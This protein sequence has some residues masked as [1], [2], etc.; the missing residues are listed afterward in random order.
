MSFESSGAALFATPDRIQ[1]PRT[2]KELI[3]FL[4]RKMSVLN[5]DTKQ[6]E[7]MPGIDPGER[8]VTGFIAELNG[9]DMPELAKAFE[10]VHTGEKRLKKEKRSPT[11]Q[12]ELQFT[13]YR[14]ILQDLASTA[15]INTE[16]LDANITKLPDEYGQ[17]EEK[18]GEIILSYYELLLKGVNN[19]NQPWKGV[20]LQRVNTLKKQGSFR[21][22]K[23]MEK[24]AEVKSDTVT[25]KDI[26][27]DN[28]SQKSKDMASYYLSYLSQQ[29][30]IRDSKA[31][32]AAE[33]IKNGAYDRTALPT[34]LDVRRNFADKLLVDL[35]ARLPVLTSFD[36]KED[37]QKAHV[38]LQDAANIYLF[39]ALDE[40]TP[41]P[42]ATD[43]KNTLYQQVKDLTTDGMGLKSLNERPAF[44]RQL[45]AKQL[46]ILVFYK[47]P[48]LNN[49]PASELRNIFADRLVLETKS[50]AKSL[51]DNI[52][53]ENTNEH[54][55]NAYRL[56]TGSLDTLYDLHFDPTEKQTDTYQAELKEKY[57][58]IRNIASSDA[59]TLT[60]LALK[61]TPKQ[62]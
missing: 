50:L 54:I 7:K 51:K 2:A 43:K 57:R 37:A 16:L 38:R 6:T 11:P 34:E 23:T 25:W 13:N 14:M 46:A 32:Q 18:I 39:Y 22:S 26:K 8:G 49:L 5:F 36:P 28:F 42:I 47:D 30:Q 29:D 10:I 35:D 21:I 27:P 3:H 59:R 31:K 4:G 1:T 44:L 15:G 48:F 52:R 33:A 58:Q 53:F 24:I 62:L 19:P 56:I 40:P 41:T 9:R 45:S 60:E 61:K 17:G 12:M 20:I 55:S